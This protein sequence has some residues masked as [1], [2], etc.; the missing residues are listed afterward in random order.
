MEVTAGRDALFLRYI[1]LLNCEGRYEE[2]YDAI[3]SRKFHPWEGGEG[4]AS[5]QYKFSLIHMAME[6][7]EKG[8]AD[9]AIE[10]LEKTFFYPHNLGEGKLF[11]VPDNQA[12]YLMGKAYRIK[13]YEETAMKW[14]ETTTTG[15]TEPGSVLYYNDQ[16]SDF[17]YFQGLA[18]RELG[19]EHA[20]KKAFY[21]LIAYGEKHIFDEVGYDFFAVS[22]PEIEVYADDIALRSQQYCRYL[23]ALGHKGVG[24]TEKVNVLLDEVLKLQ[25]EHQ[26]ALEHRI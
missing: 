1:T 17:I 4:K 25:P 8:E 21:K 9:A 13:G 26:G 6:H 15:D 23:R 22:L 3:M 16:P 7:M 19:N 18:H 24:E 11:N 14:F 2:A 20:A 5:A 10:K 12:W